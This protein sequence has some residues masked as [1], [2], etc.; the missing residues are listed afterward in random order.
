MIASPTGC[1]FSFVWEMWL[2][3]PTSLPILLLLWCSLYSSARPSSML[4]GSFVEHGPL[5]P[6]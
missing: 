3:W 4:A 6:G 2:P 5:P 1:R